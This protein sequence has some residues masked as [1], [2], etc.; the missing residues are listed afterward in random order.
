M[1]ESTLCAFLK[2]DYISFS[3]EQ[4]DERRVQVVV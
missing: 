2:Q 4:K 1:V 3:H